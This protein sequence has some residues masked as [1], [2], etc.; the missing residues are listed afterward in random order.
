MRDE[1]GS[2]ATTSQGAVVAAGAELSDVALSAPANEGAVRMAAAL[3][4]GVAES[5]K[6]GLEAAASLNAIAVEGARNVVAH[7]YRPG[8]DGP[9]WMRICPPSPRSDKREVTISFRDAGR[10][11]SIWPTADVP[12]GLGLA[13]ICE[14]SERTQIT[15]RRGAGTEIEASVSVEDSFRADASDTL[16]ASAGESGIDFQ[17]KELLGSVLPRALGAH[18]EGP[19]TTVDQIVEASRLGDALAAD[20]V[21]HEGL[22][23]PIRVPYRSADADAPLEVL[24]GPLEGSGA[25]RLLGEVKSGWQGRPGALHL[26]AEASGSSES[27]ARIQLDLAAR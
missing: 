16:P 3:A 11:C 27:T 22:V 2:T 6:L 26:S 9:L 1:Q 24:V 10:G 5:L 25:D 13:L 19:G 23:P 20:L 4:S 8:E 21:Q 7:A 17:D 18:V 15:S 14:L 12:Q